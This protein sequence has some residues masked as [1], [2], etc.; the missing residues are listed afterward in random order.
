MYFFIGVFPLGGVVEASKSD[1]QGE[2]VD[3]RDHRQQCWRIWEGK[4]AAPGP[5]SRAAPQN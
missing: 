4:A 2:A 1:D 5:G 3:G